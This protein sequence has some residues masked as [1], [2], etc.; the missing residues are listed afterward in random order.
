[1]ETKTIKYQYKDIQYCYQITDTQI[2]QSVRL[3]DIQTQNQKE[4]DFI[5]APSPLLIDVHMEWTEDTMYL[6]S[7]LPMGTKDF[8]WLKKQTNSQKISFLY[9]LIQLKQFI[10]LPIAPTL[11]PNNLVIDYKLNPLFLYR[12][13]KGLMP[14]CTFVEADIVRF[15]KYLA[16]T[17]YT[18]YTFEDIE[19]GMYHDAI[20]KNKFL[21]EMDS[22]T[23]LESL[24]SFF[25]TVYEKAI[26]EENL[27]KRLVNRKFYMMWK[28]CAIWF[29][30][31]L[32]LT[33]LPLGYFTFEKV[34]EDQHFLE[35]DK[36]FIIQKYDQTIQALDHI[37]LEKLPQTQ[38]YE[39]AYSYVE[40][41]GFDDEQKQHIMQNLTLK[42]DQNYLDFWIEDGRGNLDKA[43]SIAKKLE[44]SNL[45]QY[46]LLEK[47]DA[48]R[49]DPKM[50]DAK[51]EQT[52]TKLN[53]EYKQLQ[54]QSSGNK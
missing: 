3:A 19:G 1:M 44:D 21:K 54:E 5:T 10:D 48:V 52:L 41:K 51:R 40:S 17:L 20:V 47:M 2:I 24:E 33:L 26:Q 11:H 12:G 9:Q 30:V 16:A 39:L 35:A 25:S 28:Q 15:I 50:K 43:L 31:I 53:E 37:K 32:I 22:I 13:F 6:E 46:A 29:G 18:K 23:T 7:S 49:N 34:P 45:I 4:V 38:R 27:N 42:S 8:Y 14:N 36:A